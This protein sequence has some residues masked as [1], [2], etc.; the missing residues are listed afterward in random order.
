M[1]FADSL[2]TER[3]VLSCYEQTSSSISCCDVS[4]YAW[5]YQRNA[6]KERGRQLA[7]GPC[8]VAA[9]SVAGDHSL[10]SLPMC[11]RLHVSFAQQ[12]GGRLAAFNKAVFA[13]IYGAG[14]SLCLGRWQTQGRLS[15]R[16]R[17]IP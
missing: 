12:R 5:S 9:P 11:T 17:Q 1:R 8:A 3:S 16:S 10:M 15:P 4:Y 7:A 2:Q 6:E 14:G 13:S